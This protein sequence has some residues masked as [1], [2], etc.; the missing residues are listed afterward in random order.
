MSGDPCAGFNQEHHTNSRDVL[1]S[2]FGHEGT[3]QDVTGDAC[4]AFEK[5]RC[6]ARQQPAAVAAST[7]GLGVQGG[8]H[9][10]GPRD[11]RCAVMRVYGLELRIRLHAPTTRQ[12]RLLY[13][14]K[15][16][17]LA[18]LIAKI[19]IPSLIQSHRPAGHLQRPL[20]GQAAGAKESVYAKGL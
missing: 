15:S 12:A 16:Y 11:G 6:V 10:R 14:L 17:R 8:G 5:K 9:I 3:C 20:H 7:Q 18:P 2:A 13:P 4:A 1:D 19:I